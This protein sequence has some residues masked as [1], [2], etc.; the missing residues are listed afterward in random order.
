MHPILKILHESDHSPDLLLR[1]LLLVLPHDYNVASSSLQLS[2]SPATTLGI[3][4]GSQSASFIVEEKVLLPGQALEGHYHLGFEFAAGWDDAD[5]DRRG[6]SSSDCGWRVVEDASVGGN[7]Y[8]VV[9]W[10]VEGELI[11]DTV[12]NNALDGFFVFGS[13]LLRSR[14]GI[15]VAHLAL[16]ERVALVLRLRSAKIGSPSGRQH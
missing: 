3:D 7:E 1:K 4:V 6:E 11:A 10:L 5:D 14:L 13:D 9:Q 15:L 16:I 2:T 12:D 8:C